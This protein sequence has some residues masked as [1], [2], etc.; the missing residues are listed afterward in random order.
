[1]E[2]SAGKNL[3]P[4]LN[5]Y[6]IQTISPIKGVEYFYNFITKELTSKSFL[7]PSLIIMSTVCILGIF[8]GPVLCGWVCPFGSMQEFINGFGK[9][10]FK[11]KYDNINPKLDKALRWLRI[12]SLFVTIIALYKQI[13]ILDDFDPTQAMYSIFVQK[14]KIAGLVIFSL[15]LFLSLF[16]GRPYCRYLC[17][18][19]A[20][21]G[22]SNLIRIFTIR[23]NEENCSHCNK[24]NDVCPMKLHPEQRKQLRDVQCISCLECTSEQHCPHDKALEFSMKC[25]KKTHKM[26]FSVLFVII[27]GIVLSA[28][29]I[30]ST[31]AYWPFLKET[32]Y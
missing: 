31:L 16:I 5:E 10:I 7:L 3:I 24:C 6:A 21:V 13:K 20:L 12:I 26:P 17:P 14:Y 11:D 19:G 15:S 28:I 29:L 23:K 27:L 4:I 2:I 8:F 9:K 1:M 25:G 18:Y 30:T 22:F 32:L